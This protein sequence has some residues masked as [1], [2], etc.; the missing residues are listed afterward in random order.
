MRSWQAEVRRDRIRY[1]LGAN[2][3]SLSA[4]AEQKLEEAAADRIRSES[5]DVDLE[6]F[7]VV[8][9]V[10]VKGEVAQVEYRWGSPLLG[11]VRAQSLEVS[12]R[13]VGLA[14]SDLL[15]G[16]V[17]IEGVEAGE[18]E[19]K[20]PLSEIGRLL[21]RDVRIHQGQ[22]VV[23]LTPATEVVGS[24]SASADGLVLTAGPLEPVAADFDRGI[25]PCAPRVTLD[26]RLVLLRCSFRGLPPLFRS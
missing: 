23:S 1:R 16:D 17:R 21:E 6:G 22:I 12:L 24:V 7:P 13:G 18:L 10:L 4:F 9:R 19:V 26:N 25:M 8:A 15:N 2:G 3:R 14:R 11:R 20:I 5:V